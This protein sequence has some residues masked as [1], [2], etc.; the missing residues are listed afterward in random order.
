MCEFDDDDFDECPFCGDELFDNGPARIATM[1][2]MK[3]MMSS[4]LFCLVY[5]YERRN[6]N[7]ANLFV[8]RSG[9]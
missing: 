1:T 7:E 5:T 8:S 2:A 6:R 3:T 4:D 9:S